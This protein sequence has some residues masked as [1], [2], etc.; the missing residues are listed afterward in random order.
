MRIMGTKYCGHDSALCL[1]DTEQKTVFAMSTERVTRIKHDSL[2]ISPIVEAYDF[3]SVDY[4]AHSYSDFED[5][6]H[7]G[8]LREKMTHNKDIE[9][10]LRSII[11]PTYAADLALSRLEKNICIFKSLFTNFSAVK[12]YYSAKFNRAL[13][14]ETPEGNRRAFTNYIQQNLNKFNLKPKKI[15]FYDYAYKKF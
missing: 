11:K 5:K 12:A 15:F 6:G 13:V 3:G 9:K 2:D 14:K 10:A 1:L 8:E 4:A 7:D